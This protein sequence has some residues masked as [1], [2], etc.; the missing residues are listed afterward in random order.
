MA[1]TC[2]RAA[3]AAVPSLAP[4]RPRLSHIVCLA[5]GPDSRASKPRR[6]PPPPPPGMQMANPNLKVV[7]V[8]EVEKQAFEGVVQ[9]DK[10]EEQGPS[11]GKIAALA[12]GDFISI[13]LFAAVGH[14]SH[15][16]NLDASEIFMTALPFWLGWFAT[17]PFL[18]GYSKDIQNGD[19][20]AGAAVKSWAAGIP[21]GLAL[22]SAMKGYVPAKSFFIVSLVATFAFLMTW[23]TLYASQVA[24]DPDSKKR[25]GNKSGSIVELFSLIG[26][27]TRRW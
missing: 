8:E 21:A 19:A 16:S 20:A 22:R 10:G 2:S 13:L 27:L 3:R 18:G 6:R 15:S 5:A 23:R 14:F 1:L 4:A 12:G 9:V 7:K 24:P 25:R 11:A 17:S 26:S